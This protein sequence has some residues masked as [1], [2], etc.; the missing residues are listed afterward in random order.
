[1]PFIEGGELYKIF[2]DQKKFDEAF[3]K[4]YISQIVM[5][6]GKLHEEGI[7]HRDLKL[8]NIMMC[9]DGY[10]KLID[11]GLAKA[12]LP[13]ELISSYVGTSEYMAPELRMRNIIYDKTVDWWAVGVL[14]YEM[15]YGATPFFNRNRT[16]LNQNITD[17]KYRFP[18][19]I[20]TSD[21]FKDFISKLLVKEPSQRLG[22]HG[23]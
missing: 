22:A 4:F 20:V 15:A 18:S 21:D 19:R 8:E 17:V 16:K 11:F 12:V 14:A 5:G 9:K 13:N 10:L 1:M 7:M 6:L 3:V 2:A 23:P